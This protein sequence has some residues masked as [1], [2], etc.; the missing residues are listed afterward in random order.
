MNVFNHF[1]AFS[2]ILLIAGCGSSVTT[3]DSDSS[4]ESSS[5]SEITLSSCT[6]SIADG[7]SDFY[8]NY[9]K[10]VT[11]T[12]GTSSAT[13]ASINLPPHQSYYYGLDH[14]NYADFDTSR[15]SQYQPNPNEIAQQ[16][17]SI[18]IS[19]NPTAKGITVTEA[20]V[21]GTVGT[22]DEEYP[23]GAAGIALDGVGL[24]NPLA[25]PGDDI[26]D[27]KFTFDDY[28]AHPTG[29]DFYHY[30][31]ASPGP[32]EVLV[33]LGFSTTSTPGSAEIEIYGI[34]C[35][36]TIVLGCT[37]LDGSAPQSSGFDAQNG[38][39]HDLS[40]AEGVVIFSS[41]YH[42]HLCPTQFTAYKYTPEIQYYEDC[43]VE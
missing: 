12:Q 31:T 7:A 41:R 29:G 14:P 21:D 15:G 27:E 33:A 3:S 2:I 1:R 18:S 43:V 36:G 32:L 11:V 30:H 20:L 42:T 34:M 24:F 8:K 5:N 10:C 22:S 16:S 6:T 26:E 9:F 23:M 25:A 39:V 4:A 13:L 37:E 19:D 38:H 28:N 17:I 35:D 40:D